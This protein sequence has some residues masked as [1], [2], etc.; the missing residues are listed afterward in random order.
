VFYRKRYEILQKLSTSALAVLDC[1]KSRPEKRL[2]VGDIV[3]ETGL[4][5]RTVQYALKTL[6]GQKFLQLLGRGSASR[7]QLVF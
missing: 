2:K 6:T 5:R 1:F 7:Y 3:K 4:P